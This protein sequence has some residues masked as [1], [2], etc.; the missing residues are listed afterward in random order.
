[1]MRKRNF[2][3]DLPKLVST[4]SAPFKSRFPRLT[5]TTEAGGLQEWRPTM[6]RQQQ[7]HGYGAGV[8]RRGS[9]VHNKSRQGAGSCFARGLHRCAQEQQAISRIPQRRQGATGLCHDQKRRRQ[10]PGAEETG[11][12]TYN[13]REID[14]ERGQGGLP[15]KPRLHHVERHSEPGNV[16]PHIAHLDIDGPICKDTRGRLPRSEA[17]LACAVAG[18][19]AHGRTSS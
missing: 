6:E 19:S 17:A 16:P 2:S 10:Q 3:F 8:S 12:C 1:M 7:R 11:S 13:P 5:N 18:R 9:Q 4:A 15:P 14:L